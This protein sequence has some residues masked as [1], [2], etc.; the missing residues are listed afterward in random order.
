MV[1]FPSRNAVNH[2]ISPFLDYPVTIKPRPIPVPRHIAECTF[3]SNQKPSRAA[4]PG[5]NIA[6]GRSINQS[7]DW[8]A[9]PHPTKGAPACLARV[10]HLAL[11]LLTGP[12]NFQMFHAQDSE[13]L[14]S[15]VVYLKD[16]NMNG[17]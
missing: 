14:G 2:S 7:L 3:N 12:G 11:K 6:M 8:G 16:N 1:Y 13:S 4:R 5:T 15:G 17:F 10:H 9:C